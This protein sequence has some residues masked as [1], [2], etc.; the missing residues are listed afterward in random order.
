MLTARVSPCERPHFQGRTERRL[1]E[2]VQ[3]APGSMRGA[4]VCQGSARGAA[5]RPTVE[6]GYG[7]DG[8]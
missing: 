2:R 3:R 5:A 7:A 6:A 8:A 4:G 1:P